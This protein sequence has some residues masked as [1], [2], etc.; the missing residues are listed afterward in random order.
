[1][2]PKS[3]PRRA[4]T[5]AATHKAQTAALKAAADKEKKKK[6]EKKQKQKEKAEAEQKALDEAVR[7]AEAERR[8]ASEAATANGEEDTAGDVH[9]EGS[10]PA[11]GM[12]PG[13]WAKVVKRQR[14]KNGPNTT[15]RSPGK[16]TPDQQLQQDSGDDS[17][18]EDDDDSE[19][20]T[21][22]QESGQENI[23]CRMFLGKAGKEHR[24]HDVLI[25]YYVHY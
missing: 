2:P 10:P 18:S 25:V 20:G 21:S 9:M 22:G 14:G 16:V 24:N 23:K 1:M 4:K 15:L 19:S 6:E 8:A 7:R 13:E 17:N 3:V 11:V 5:A 12:S